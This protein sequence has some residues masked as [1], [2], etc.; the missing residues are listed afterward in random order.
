MK[1][2]IITVCYNSKE[3]IKDT[4]ESVINQSYDNIEYIIIDGNS[5]DNTCNIIN[6]YSNIDIFISE[7]DK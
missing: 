1:I 6:S 3:T 4:I 5:N 7:N 2:S